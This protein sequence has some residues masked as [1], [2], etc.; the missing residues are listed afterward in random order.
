MKAIFNTGTKVMA[1]IVTLLITMTATA[2]FSVNGPGTNGSGIN[3]NGTPNNSPTVPLDGG[4]SLM[5]LISGIGYGAKKLK[6][7]RDA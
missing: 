5:L 4:M 7:A 3:A 2:Q 6:R 1:T